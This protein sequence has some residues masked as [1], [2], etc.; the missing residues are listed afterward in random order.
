MP[1]SYK[2]QHDYLGTAR[3]DR[4]LRILIEVTA[5]DLTYQLPLTN[6]AFV[7]YWGDGENNRI[8]FPEYLLPFTSHTYDTP[9]YYNVLVQLDDEA[10]DRTFDLNA[11]FDRPF[12]SPNAV[13]VLSWGTLEY[14]FVELDTPMV[15]RDLPQLKVD[16]TFDPDNYQNHFAVLKGGSDPYRAA[17]TN[18]DYP[19]NFASWDVSQVGL[20]D[21]TFEDIA[22]FNQ[23]LSAWDTGNIRSLGF[24][25]FGCEQF[26]AN[27]SGWDTSNLLSLNNTFQGAVSFDQDLNSWDVSKLRSLKDTFRNSVLFPAT[28][29]SYTP[30]EAYDLIPEWQ[31]PYI[32]NYRPLLYPA[33]PYFTSPEEYTIAIPGYSGDLSNWDTS[34]V[35]N[36]S[37]TFADN[38]S[39]DYTGPQEPDYLVDAGAIQWSLPKEYNGANPN[40]S[41][42]NTSNVTDF[43]E[44][45]YLNGGFDGDISAWDTSSAVTMESMFQS[46]IYFNSNI[47]AWNVSNV[48]NMKGT[49]ASAIRFNQPIGNWNTGNVTNMENMFNAAVAFNQDISDW[50]TSNVTNM[51]GML[52]SVSN[53]NYPIGKWDTS[54]V[55]TVK[56][57][58][59]G[60]TS[61]DRSL[62]GWNVESLLPIDSPFGDYGYV[63]FSDTAMSNSNYDSTLASW[64]SQTVNSGITLIATGKQVTTPEGAAGRASLIAQGWTIIDG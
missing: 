25:F 46:A 11:G 20:L 16:N 10:S 43:S 37:G 60:A 34:N 33:P 27:I 40:I 12:D 49:F 7:V 6:N 53:F 2:M 17:L 15:T 63:D 28:Y 44:M 59:G 19:D 64:G 39:Q 3:K 54:K 35:T 47:S 55:T 9:G 58:F 4:G 30:G 57:M 21:R 41:T 14:N 8:T 5:E 32:V 51:K 23:D 22:D 24:T 1:F 48:T 56:F 45:F 36:M 50:D 31:L 26:N 62:S 38:A 52:S 29:S 61:F 18:A 13:R 42:W